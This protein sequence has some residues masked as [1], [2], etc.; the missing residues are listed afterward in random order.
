MW[1]KTS[2]TSLRHYYGNSCADRRARG[3]TD[4]RT[5]RTAD[6]KKKNECTTH[7][8][9]DKSP[10]RIAGCRSMHTKQRAGSLIPR[11][12][13][14]SRVQV[15]GPAPRPHRRTERTD[16]A[17][18]RQ[19][20]TGKQTMHF[21]SIPFCGWIAAGAAHACLNW[22]LPGDIASS[23]PDPNPPNPP[24]KKDP[25]FS[26]PFLF[27]GMSLRGRAVG[28]WRLRRRSLTARRWHGPSCRGPVG[29][30]IAL[31]RSNA[32]D[33]LTFS[34]SQLQSGQIKMFLQVF[35]E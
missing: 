24:R 27:G 9:S 6:R 16:E 8:Q 20:R 25:F 23:Q 1:S 26:G 3:H 18:G 30:T 19:T 2:P 31:P 33:S 22:P 28:R 34:T 15:P 32:G 7:Q 29:R 14:D 10:L 17:A 12:R 35:Y 13:T 11:L 4:I 5:D 21:P